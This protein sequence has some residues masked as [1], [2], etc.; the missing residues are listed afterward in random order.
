MTAHTL[1]NVPPRRCSHLQ[2]IHYRRSER[3]G[4]NH[5][6]LRRS[7]RR[8]QSG[9]MTAHVSVDT[10]DSRNC[11]KSLGKLD[12]LARDA[13]RRQGQGESQASAPAIRQPTVQ[14]DRRTYRKCASAQ[15]TSPSQLLIA[16]HDSASTRHQR[17]PSTSFSASACG[18]PLYFLS[19]PSSPRTTMPGVPR[20]PRASISC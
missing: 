2:A 13:C 3:R 19:E 18:K 12:Q 6:N 9:N 4:T 20:N 7:K 1:N 16:S 15:R 11:M 17:G 8:R 14:D 5:V 10:P